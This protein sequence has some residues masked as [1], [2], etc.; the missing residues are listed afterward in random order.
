MRLNQPEF[1][2]G[3]V[4][5]LETIASLD[6]GATVFHCSAGKDR[7]G[8]LAAVIL[9]ILGVPD[10]D[11]VRDY[12][13]SARYMPRQIDYWWEND[14]ESSPYFERLLAYMY[15]SRPETMEHVLETLYRKHGSIR[16]YVEAHGGNE[17]L[18]GRLEDALL[19]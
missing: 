10:E 4:E 5:A 7:A 17:S 16:G 8:K 14:P 11:I 18:F 9:G 2:G 15:D 13:M 19:E 12:A 3:I 6:K 1:G